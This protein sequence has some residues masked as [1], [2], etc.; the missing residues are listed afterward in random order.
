MTLLAVHK[1]DVDQ[2]ERLLSGPTIPLWVRIQALEVIFEQPDDSFAVH[3]FNRLFLPFSKSMAGDSPF[4]VEHWLNCEKRLAR[5][6]RLRHFRK[7]LLEAGAALPLLD[8]RLLDAVFGLLA[9]WTQ[10]PLSLSDWSDAARMAW[11]FLESRRR[12]SPKDL[13]DPRL[14]RVALWA[15]NLSLM[16]E[17]VEV[18]IEH[19]QT[20]DELLMTHYIVGTLVSFDDLS[21]LCAIAQAMYRKDPGHPRA[22]HNLLVTLFAKGESAERLGDLCLEMDLNKDP[23]FAP[24][25]LSW[26]GQ[27]CFDQG[28]KS[29]AEAVFRLAPPD[30]LQ[31][32]FRSKSW[33]Q[34]VL[35]GLAET[36]SNPETLRGMD[37]LE[38]QGLPHA[39]AGPLIK[40][41]DLAAL[42]IDWNCPK[43]AAELADG[44]RVVVDELEAIPRTE[45][46]LESTVRAGERMIALA[47]AYFEPY[48]HI[49]TSP[50]AASEKYGRLDVRRMK[51]AYVGLLQIAAATAAIGLEAILDGAQMH[52]MEQCLRLME[53]YTFAKLGADA[54]SEALPLLERFLGSLAAGDKARRCAESCL[55]ALGDVARAR[56]LSKAARAEGEIYGVADHETWGRLEGVSWET[57]FEDTPGFGDFEVT[58]PDGR[59]VRYDHEVPA[60][61]MRV[62][63]HACLIVRRGEVLR[64]REDVILRPARFHYPHRYPG[65]IPDLLAGGEAAVRLKRLAPP[66]SIAEPVV[67]LENFDA[68]FH[69]NYYHWTALLL[70][71]VNYLMTHSLMKGRRLV[72][73]SGL[74]SWM[75]ASL[76]AIGG[77]PQSVLFAPMDEELKFTDALLCASVEFAS[78]TLLIALRDTL[79]SRD[80]PVSTD[81][82]QHIYLSRQGHTRRPFLNERDIEVMAARLG[83]TV[84]QPETLSFE[85][86]A[87]LFHRAVGVVGAEGAAFTNTIF[88]QPG[89]TRVLTLLNENDMFPT[90]NDIATVCG[91]R[92]R[93]LTGNAV[94]DEYG[95]NY[96]WAP[97]RIDPEL[98]KRDMLWALEG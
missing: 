17:I 6:E 39:L 28:F 54:A 76:Q 20:A 48:R 22:V 71:R 42:D 43:T 47:R 88:C 51:A 5:P 14:Q 68:L 38:L 24:T 75:V 11:N 16:R 13:I 32:G 53:C 93:K 18:S 44:C 25:A 89:R 69:R 77:G 63:R 90:Y 81:V 26:I 7:A 78:P 4:L 58:W 50:I 85:E 95:L 23:G 87:C 86:Q 57:L 19:S 82:P 2:I 65:R 64:G 41:A 74:P 55:L 59:Q 92:H 9:T 94:R 98:A 30:S 8:E 52:S 31:L 83:F 62:A 40:A 84:V 36:A 60:V 73:P 70:S 96:V 91:L 33:P 34:K 29:K 66:T 49:D 56:T 72:V 21:S 15:G 61:R 37:L 67:V 3:C 1:R 79:L 10:R 46:L 27:I 35:L 97:F 45:D 80:S 12:E